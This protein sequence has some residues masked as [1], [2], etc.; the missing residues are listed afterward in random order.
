MPQIQLC[1]YAVIAVKGMPEVFKQRFLK[2][3]GV[4]FGCIDTW[5]LPRCYTRRVCK[6]LRITEPYFDEFVVDSLPTPSVHKH[7]YTSLNRYEHGG[8]MIAVRN[9]PETLDGIFRKF[10]GVFSY[11]DNAWILPKQ[12]IRRVL[13]LLGS[14]T[15]NYT[16]P[17]VKID[18]PLLI[19]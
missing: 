8:R 4:Y 3:N 14:K 10:C 12:H 18:K 13:R 15:I 5:L 1:N 9:A 2:F 7:K 17:C 16:K 6:L 19:L 11:C